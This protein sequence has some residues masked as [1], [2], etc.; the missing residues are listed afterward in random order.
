M[1]QL[2]L[3]FVQSTVEPDIQDCFTPAFNFTKINSSGGR[4]AFTTGKVYWLPDNPMAMLD[5]GW[6]IN[7][8]E[9][10]S[11][12]KWGLA[13]FFIK[14]KDGKEL[15]FIP[16]FDWDNRTPGRMIVWVPWK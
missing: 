11:Y 3:T 1:E 10:D 4:L 7:V 9:I 2:P 14:L 8:D 16:Y 13:G 5:Q 12:G 15:R 6:V